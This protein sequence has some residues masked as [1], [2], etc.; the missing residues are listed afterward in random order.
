MPRHELRHCFSDHATSGGKL[1]D[2]AQFQREGG[3]GNRLFHMN[4]H[5]TRD[6][7]GRPHAAEHKANCGVV[8]ETAFETSLADEN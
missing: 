4:D 5:M 2:F 1:Q 7:V 3:F 6:T 8:I